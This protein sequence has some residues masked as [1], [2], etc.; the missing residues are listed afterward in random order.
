MMNLG[1]MRARVATQTQ[2]DMRR[3]FVDA[4]WEALRPLFDAHKLRGVGTY[5][6]DIERALH[7]AADGAAHNSLRAMDVEIE[8]AAIAAMRSRI[9][10]G[11][12]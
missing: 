5:W 2:S 12:S 7:A 1:P 10:G 3:A 4:A 6:N 11:R 8:S 9:N